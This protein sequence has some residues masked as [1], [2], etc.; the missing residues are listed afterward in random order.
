MQSAT[1][2]KLLT[3]PSVTFAKPALDRIR[4]AEK[5]GLAKFP[6]CIAKTQFSFSADAKQYGAVK[7]FNLQ[8][9][10]IVLNAGAEMVVAIAGDIIRMPGLPKDPQ[11]NHIDFVDGEIVVSV[12][13]EEAIKNQVIANMEKIANDCIHCEYFCETC[14]RC[15]IPDDDVDEVPCRCKGCPDLCKEKGVCM[16]G[17]DI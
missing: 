16:R 14:G 1:N 11:A 15:S 13:D 4:L 7:G 6:V 9:R 10:D 3:N 5:Y 8:I 2:L 12:V 17:E